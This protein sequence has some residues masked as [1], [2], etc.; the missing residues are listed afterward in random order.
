FKIFETLP[1]I[2]YAQNMVGKAVHA[3]VHEENLEKTFQTL[4]E[5]LPHYRILV[6]ETGSSIVL[7]I[8]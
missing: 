8:K 2:G 5:K 3:L 6:G 4:R 7:N 1:T